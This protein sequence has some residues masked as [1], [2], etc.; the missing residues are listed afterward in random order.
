MLT[1][2][3][4]EQGQESSSGVPAGRAL[5]AAAECTAT[6]KR[7]IRDTQVR[8]IALLTLPSTAVSAGAVCSSLQGCRGRGPSAWRC[9]RR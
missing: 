6:I 2:L 9:G 4:Q 5:K 1:V 8:T 7:Q 3:P